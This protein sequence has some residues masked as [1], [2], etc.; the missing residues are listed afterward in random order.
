MIEVQAAVSVKYGSRETSDILSTYTPTTPFL[1]T[2]HLHITEWVIFCYVRGAWA[3]VFMKRVKC[4]C[5][6]GF[7]YFGIIII[8]IIMALLE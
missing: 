8:I 6:N 3:T 7:N 1:F 2:T 5:F 4:S